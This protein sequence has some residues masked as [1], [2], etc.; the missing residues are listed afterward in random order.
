MASATVEAD[1]NWLSDS[2]ADSA[3]SYTLPTTVNAG[4][5][6][7]LL[8]AVDGAPTGVS[9]TDSTS[10]AWTQVFSDDDGA[11]AQSLHI[12]EKIADGDEDAGSVTLSWTGSEKSTGLVLRVTSAHASQ[13][14]EAAT[15]TTGATSAPDSG[16]VTA[17][18][19]AEDNLFISVVAWDIDSRSATA[20][21]TGYT[22]SSTQGDDWDVAGEGGAGGAGLAFAYK[23]TTSDA[24]DDPDAFTL[25]VGATWLGTTLVIR[26]AAGGGG[27]T[28][29]GP[30]A[31][32]GGLAGPGGLAGTVGILAR[33]MVRQGKLW[34]VPEQIIPAPIG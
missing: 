20:G 29:H 18:W 6:L 19:G 26:P 12:F 32:E 1:R 27:G 25:D 17:S 3:D 16:E 30:L 34:V 23:G 7:L 14:I 2:S 9:A 11:G 24:A 15:K 28:T 22:F 10:D 31:G 8:S 21:P 5:R 4:D 33:E 13:A